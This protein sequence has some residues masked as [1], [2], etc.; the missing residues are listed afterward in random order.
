VAAAFEEVIG[1][2]EAFS[3]LEQPSAEEVTIIG[4]DP[5]FSTRFKIGETCAAVLGGVGVA[6]TD[7]W[8]MKTGRRQKV[9][10]DVRHAAA[11][12]RSSAYLQRPGADGAFTP[13]V[14]KDHEAMR[15]ITQPWPTK[16]GRWVL[17]H[18]GLPNLQERM[19]NLLGCE[20]NP[21]SV[22]KA[23]AKWDALDLE[24][25]IEEARVCGGMV[26]SNDEW[27]AHPHGRALA[28][29]PIVEIIKIGDSDPEPLPRDGRPLS[30]IRALDLTR[31]LAGPMAARTLAEH[32]ADVMMVKAERLPQI[33]E[34]VL[35][36]SHG[37]R[38]CFLDLAQSEDASRLKVLVKGADVFSQAY[39]PGMIGK[40]GFGPEEVAALRPGIIY[41]SINCYGADG[42]FS[43]RGGWEQ[44]AQTMTGLCHEGR[45]AARPNGPALLP[46]AACDYTT[47]Y[48]A[49][50]GIL[51]ALA[52]RARDGGSYHV[53][54]SLCQSGMFI[55]RQGKVAFPGLGLD[56]SAAELDAIRIES[57]PKSGPL[58]HLGP[59]LE[60]SEAQPHWTRPTPQLGGDA[61][62]WL[63][64]GTRAAAAE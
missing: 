9:S 14:N 12:L 22:A 20:L 4:A 54:V 29:K 13:V 49:A 7:I 28:A 36:T 44:V 37:K 55:Y 5:V 43:H 33:P 26:R 15:A 27:L 17:P 64:V 21:E 60:F 1:V 62:E 18:F 51:L 57:R 3:G 39:R 63:E 59:I 19:Q 40:F 50:Y 53:S 34:H 2:R 30:G 42:P 35:D 56:L 41:A 16:D 6:V 23:V 11:G 58:R 61:P 32:G 46:A 10:I 38:S 8:E 48:L 24:A 31:I 45:T 52:K 47:G 25:A